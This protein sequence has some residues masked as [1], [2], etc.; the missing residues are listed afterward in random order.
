MK[1]SRTTGA[2][3]I[4]AVAALALAGCGS[5][6][7][8]GT[9]A[10]SSGASGGTTNAAAGSDCASA[11]LSGAG[12]SFQAPM[13]EQWISQ[14]IQK[15]AG[16]QINY[17]SVGSGAGIQQ[18]GQGTID[19]AGSDVV[20]KQ[21]EQQAADKRCGGN[22]AI[23]LPVTAGGVAITYNLQ[24]VDKLKLSPDTLAGIFQGSIKSWDAP[25]IKQDNAGT[26]LPSTPITVFHRSDGS[27]TTSV[28]SSYMAAAAGSK[29]TLG[30]GK[31]LNWSTGQG[32]KGNEGVSA[33]VGQ[34]KGGIT[35]TEQAFAEQKKLPMALIKNAGG[36]YVELTSANVSKALETAKVTGTG[37]D[38]SV[39]VDYTPKDP[40]AYPISTVSYVIACSS[41]PASFG[42][43]KVT[44]L[45]SYLQYAVTDGQSAA[46]GLGFAPL[47]QTLVDK[48]KSA[49]S[50]ISA[51]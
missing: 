2:V 13:E 32:A 49:I 48:D 22:T 16:T 38:V 46:Q 14:Y 43:D 27:G 12:S 19:F 44:A 9:A 10:P 26:N 47:P 5:N 8:T 51:S 24:G 23:H 31:T 34:T 6:N 21:D 37:N 40:Q 41:Y 20:M 18:F 36:S 7:N 3:G 29:W 4:A 35:Y 11:T 30:T 28:F 1:V 25:E 39:D 50:A 42:K 17:N 15:C 33:G 45:Q